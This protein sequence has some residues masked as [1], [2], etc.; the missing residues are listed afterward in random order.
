MSHRLH[1]EDRSSWTHLFLFAFCCLQMLKLPLYVMCLHANQ[2]T[3]WL[4][5]MI[6]QSHCK[7]SLLNSVCR[8]QWEVENSNCCRLHLTVYYRLTWILVW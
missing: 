2:T 6:D 1:Q 7:L 8:Q 3:I 5:I 4:T